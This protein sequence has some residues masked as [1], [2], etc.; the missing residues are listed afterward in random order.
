MHTLY[1]DVECSVKEGTQSGSKIRLK[2][3]GIVSMNHPSQ[4]G[5]HYVVI[6]I[7]VPRNLSPEAKQRL[8]EFER[9]CDGQAGA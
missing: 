9:S 2:N 3:K 1:G 6:Q 7:Q 8:K 4:R 5:D